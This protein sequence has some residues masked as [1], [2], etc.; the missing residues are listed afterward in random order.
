MTLPIMQPLPKLQVIEK[1]AV[2][3]KD[4]ATPS[5]ENHTSCPHDP[6]QA[7]VTLVGGIKSGNFTSRGIVDTFDDC[8][9]FCCDAQECDL[10]FMVKKTCFSLKC[11]NEDLCKTRTARP[12]PFNPMV[13]FIK[14]SSAVLQPK[15]GIYYLHIF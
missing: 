1:P 5:K 15:K 11:H 12:S 3:V 9:K 7:N 10:A 2:A 6:A 8:I 13:A 14:K 4:E